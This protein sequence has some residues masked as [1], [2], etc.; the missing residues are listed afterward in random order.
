MPKQQTK[1]TPP[2]SSPAAPP[3]PQPA[4]EPYGSSGPIRVRRLLSHASD[5][6]R[7]FFE[8][9][10]LEWDKGAHNLTETAFML[11]ANA[12]GYRYIAVQADAE[13][14]EH[15]ECIDTA[16]QIL[17]DGKW[18]ANF[19]RR[20]LRV[21]R[22]SKEL[23]FDTP[24]DTLFVLEQEMEDF[25]NDCEIAQGVLRD[26]PEALAAE[27]QKLAQERPELFSPTTA[28]TDAA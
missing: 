26:N 3:K 23:D 4:P 28:T 18:I 8:N 13:E 16:A 19:L 22:G 21:Y 1:P 24:E 10:M 15:L 14:K 17:F 27:L 20:L 12:L 11:S 7:D 5:E 25:D 2:N 6:S 9:L